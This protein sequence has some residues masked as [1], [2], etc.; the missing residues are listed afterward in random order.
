MGGET[1]LGVV[2]PRVWDAV[3]RLVV[4]KQQRRQVLQALLRDVVHD[5]DALSAFSNTV[6]SIGPRGGLPIRYDDMLATSALPDLLAER[7]ADAIHQMR[8]SF[9][10]TRD[11]DAALRTLLAQYERLP[12]LQQALHEEFTQGQGQ[13]LWQD[14]LAW[15]E[16]DTRHGQSLSSHPDETL[17]L[18]EVSEQLRRRWFAFETTSAVEMKRNACRRSLA[19][20]REQCEVIMGMVTAE[21]ALRPIAALRP[22][23][24]GLV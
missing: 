1:L 11:L 5:R 6:Q 3:M 15:E 22:D 14:Y 23:R 8:H 17:R 21:L 12:Q 24:R 13:L 18:S 7:E 10:P 16:A 20:A 2:V 19:E 9:P 4:G